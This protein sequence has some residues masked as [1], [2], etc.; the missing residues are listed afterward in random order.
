M[1]ENYTTYD[2]LDEDGDLTVGVSQITVST[3]RYDA[4]S[5]VTDNKG[6]GH[7]GDF[8]HT[9][10][11]KK[12]ASDT[13]GLALFW[14]MSNGNF[15]HQEMIDNTDG[16]SAAHYKTD[17]GVQRLYLM[18]YE[19]S[20]LNDY[21][22]SALNTD[23]WLTI[24]RSGITVTCKIYLDAG[25]TILDDTLL[26]V[27]DAT[28][29]Q[30]MIALGSMNAT[31]GGYDDHTITCTIND[32]DLNEGAPN[33]HEPSDTANVIDAV[34]FKI[35]KSIS[36]IANAIDDVSFKVGKPISDMVNVLDDVFY[37]PCP[38]QRFYITSSTVTISLDMPQWG[39]ENRLIN[40]NIDIINFW[41]DDLETIDKDKNSEPLILSGIETGG[42]LSTKFENIWEIQ[43]SHEEVTVTGLG[44]C[45]DGIYIIK[46]FHFETIPKNIYYFRWTMTLEFVR[47]I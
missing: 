14:G 18:R 17:A 26:V 46:S 3:M 42:N 13:R 43:N 40:K 39:G 35:G 19:I 38:K 8:E 12:T 23:Y 4:R 29:Y 22:A 2:E 1:T 45:I 36:D 31:G 33:I 15:T 44:N 27:A 32:L 11:T 24:E 34:S 28:T 9:V 21:Y 41:T 6:I 47:G 5:C 25:R 30:Y 7:F 37:Q 10:Q 16:L 20:Y